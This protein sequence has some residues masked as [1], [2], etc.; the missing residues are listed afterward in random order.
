MTMVNMLDAKTRLSKLVE[1]VVSFIKVCNRRG[2]APGI[3]VR[4]TVLAR[5]WVERGMR[6]VGCGSELTLLLAKAQET[7]AELRG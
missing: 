4:N 3:Q 5:A 1:A 6:F 2:V 7:V